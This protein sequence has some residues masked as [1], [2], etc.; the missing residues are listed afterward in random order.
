MILVGIYWSDF[1]SESGNSSYE[2]LAN[3]PKMNL[4][5]KWV[6]YLFEFIHTTAESATVNTILKTRGITSM[7]IPTPGNITFNMYCYYDGASD[8]NMTGLQTHTVTLI[9]RITNSCTISAI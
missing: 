9:S 8:N 2:T 1:L 5:N 4:V 7:P 3:I 6:M